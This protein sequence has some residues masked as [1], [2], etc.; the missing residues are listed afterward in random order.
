MGTPGYFRRNSPGMRRLSPLYSK[1][2]HF[3]RK[4]VIKKSRSGIESSSGTIRRG[5]ISNPVEKGIGHDICEISSSLGCVAR[6]G[7]TPIPAVCVPCAAIA[8]PATAQVVGTTAVLGRGPLGPGDQKKGQ[9]K[10][11]VNWGKRFFCTPQVSA[12]INSELITIVSKVINSGADRVRVSPIALH[13]INGTNRGPEALARSDPIVAVVHPKPQ[14]GPE[15]YN[16][17]SS[18][19]VWVVQPVEP[20][21]PAR[22]AVVVVPRQL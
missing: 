15:R 7:L 9:G 4:Y 5:T 1:K 16:G 11:P 13:A 14:S 10:K 18:H 20:D 12:R 17:V 2:L 6:P 3:F 22:R 8:E 19:N 21:A